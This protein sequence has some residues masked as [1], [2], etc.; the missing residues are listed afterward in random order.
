[1][2]AP[3]LDELGARLGIVLRDPDLIR[4]AFVHSSF[5]NENPS[6][7]VGHNE[8]LEFYGDAVIGVA[9]S[10]L[11]FARY[12]DE[13]E[14]FLTARRAALVNR[15]ALGTLA[16]SIGLDR[17]LR[18]GRGEADAGG[19]MR[20]SVLAACFE[21]LAGALALSEGTERAEAVLERL[22]M[23]RLEAL[24]EIAG[25]PKSA[26]SRLQE[27]SQRHRG[28]KPAYQLVA[29][30]GPPHAQRFRVTVTVDGSLLG[31]GA[32]S[33]RQRAEEQAARAAI[34]SLVDESAPAPQSTTAP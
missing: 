28:V 33:S 8:R 24:A 4:Q 10:R 1:M 15:Q 14:G 31:S 9:I 7:A 23:P 21:A 5:F 6:L 32:G 2:D 34:A 18:L 17:Y 19:A 22:F 12:P 30:S 29:T 13:D 11:L 16:L 20:P 27:W 26:K 3:P 25:P